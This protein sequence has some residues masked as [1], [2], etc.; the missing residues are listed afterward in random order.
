MK[1]ES[2][3]PVTSW[4]SYSVAL[5]LHSNNPLNIRVVPFFAGLAQA[6]HSD[7]AILIASTV[8]LRNSMQVLLLAIDAI[9][10]H[11]ATDLAL[12]QDCLFPG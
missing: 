7:L 6:L 1:L 3:E 2:F 12:R 11:N 10:V 9:E 5:E 4:N 8:V